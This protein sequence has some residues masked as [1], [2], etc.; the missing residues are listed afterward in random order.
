ML[1]KLLLKVGNTDSMP[2]SVTH[3]YRVSHRHRVSNI[4]SVRHRHRHRHRVSNIYRVRH[5]HRVS[6][7]DTAV[8]QTKTQCVRHRQRVRHR[9]RDQ[10]QYGTMTKLLVKVGSINLWR[11]TTTTSLDSTF[12]ANC[13]T[14]GRCP[15]NLQVLLSLPLLC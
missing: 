13:K 12:F 10:P 11:N 2:A 3:I 15:L 14:I 7:T 1:T 9:H 8:C 5:S 6:V 4:E